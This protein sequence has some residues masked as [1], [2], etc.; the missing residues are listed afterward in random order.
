MTQEQVIAILEDNL[1]AFSQG[2][3]IDIDG[4]DQAASAIMELVDKEKKYSA[5]E[6]QQCWD[7]SHKVTYTNTVGHNNASD[8]LNTDFQTFLKSLDSQSQPAKN[9]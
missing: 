6:M 9:D 1:E 4:I 3:K 2:F 8:D 7:T 5:E